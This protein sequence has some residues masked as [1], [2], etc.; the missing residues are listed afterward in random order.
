MQYIS[1]IYALNIEDSTECCGDWHTSGLDWNL[2]DMRESST[3]LLKNWG[4][5]QNKEIPE[6]S[7][8]YNVANTLRAIIDL[9][10]D[11][12]LDYLKGFRNDFIMVDIYN[13]EFFEK[14]FMLRDLYNWSD[15]N[16]LMK[17]EFMF[18]WN[19]FLKEQNYG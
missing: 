4:I 18:L 15:I 5:E 3:S 1:G 13:T 6:H 19:N 14:V 10:I 16:N 12:K 7:N 11:N 8:L 17:R 9:M 2:V